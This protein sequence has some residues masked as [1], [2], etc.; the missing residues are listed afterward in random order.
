MQQ[1]SI[2]L[3][4]IK[5]IVNSNISLLIQVSHKSLAQYDKSNVLTKETFR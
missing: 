3:N 4:R 2:H 5:L 1:Q